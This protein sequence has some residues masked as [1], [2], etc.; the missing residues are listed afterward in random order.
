M[1]PRRAIILAA[2]NGT[3]M[4]SLTSDRPKALLEVAGVSLIDW[5]LNALRASGIHDVTLVT[6]YK[7]H[8]LHEHLGGK[9]TF[10]ENNRYHETN[11]LYSLWLARDELRRG[12]IVMNSDT[13]ISP[14]LLSL[15]VQ[16]PEGDA[17]LID[18]RSHLGPEEMKVS[19]S[20]GF[21]IDFGK[22]LPLERSHGENVGVLKFSPRGGTRLA[23]HLE[24]LVS[25]G[26]T[27]AWAPEAFAALARGW[28]IA[29]VSTHGLRWAEID[30]PHDLARAQRDFAPT[31]PR[32]SWNHI[33]A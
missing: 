18:L 6:G 10:V 1:H 9:V 3:R 20:N 23:R 14:M 30:F 2:G 31:E 13:L 29:A 17:A 16:A 7:A 12:S 25:A 11:S 4:G 15:L 21:V 26:H 19:L 27:R 22:D 5:Q 24:T 33:A 32:P 28:P 8:T